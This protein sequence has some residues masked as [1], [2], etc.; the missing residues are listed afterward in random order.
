MSKTKMNKR[1]EGQV[2]SRKHPYTATELDVLIERMHVRTS[3][4]EELKKRLK[5]AGGNRTVMVDGHQSIYT[6]G[7]RAFDLFINNLATELDLA[8]LD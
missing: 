4:L 2:I 7:F 1:I 3:R 6:R 8:G 5:A